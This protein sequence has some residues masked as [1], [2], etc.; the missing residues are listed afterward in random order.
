MVVQTIDQPGS[1]AGVLSESDGGAAFETLYAEAAGDATRI[2]W[3]D[4]VPN[5]ALVT[6][7]NAVAPRLIRCGGRVAVVGC[8]LGED[9]R[10]LIRR[11]FEVTAFDVSDTAVGWA[12]RLDPT[13]ECCYQR[14]DLFSPPARWRH[15][16]DLVVEI[17]TVQSLHPD[18]R[19]EVLRAAADLLGPRGA[20]LIIAQGSEFS[21]IDQDGPPWP[22]TEDEL[23]TAAIDAGLAEVGEIDSFLDDADPPR[24]RLRGLFRRA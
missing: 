24:L 15:R 19:V 16:F 2:P 23:R 12:R 14:A 20:M 8:G 7:M 3:S 11:G 6:W 5:P 13:H 4:G 21:V 10:E 17:Y 9:A 1:S 22:L 18:R